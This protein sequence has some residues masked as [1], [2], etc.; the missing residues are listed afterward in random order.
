[1]YI[2]SN[3]ES[4][5]FSKRNNQAFQSSGTCEQSVSMAEIVGRSS[6]I[7]IPDSIRNR[8]DVFRSAPTTAANNIHQTIACKFL[9]IFPTRK[10]ARPSET[11]FL[12][13]ALAIHAVNRVDK[14]VINLEWV[15]LEMVLIGKVNEMK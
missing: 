8:S 14:I 11:S 13:I 3:P 12:Y 2:G 4:G 1:M 5:G 9:E 10:V 6:W 7:A 15:P